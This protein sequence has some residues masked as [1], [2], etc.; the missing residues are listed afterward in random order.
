MLKLDISGFKGPAKALA[1]EATE[2]FRTAEELLSAYP[3]SRLKSIAVTKMEEASL[4]FY[5]LI[6]ESDFRA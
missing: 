2:V 1:D 3:P 4:W 5:Q 6:R